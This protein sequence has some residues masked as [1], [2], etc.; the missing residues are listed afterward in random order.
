MIQVSNLSKSYGTGHTSQLL[1]DNVSFNINSGE[2]IGLVGRNGHGKTTLLRLISGEETPDSGAITLPKNYIIG[3]LQQNIRFIRDTVLEEACLGLRPEHKNDFWRAEKMLSGL[4]FSQDDMNRNPSVF[5]GGFQVRLNL[6]KVLAGEPDLLLLDEPTNYLDIVSIRWLS[7]LLNSWKNELLLVTH[8]RSF[9]DSVT[10]HTMGIHRRKIKKIEGGTEKLYNQIIQEE[11]VH[12]KTRQN[13]EKRRKEIEL[14]ITRF[15]A[16]ARLG[17]LVQSRVKLLDKTRKLEKL[18]KIKTLEFS[19]REE[20]YTGK[21]TVE[22]N[23]VSFSYND[24][25]PF[26]IDKFSIV[27][28]K[29]DRIGVIGRNGKGKTTLLKLLAG[30]LQPIDGEVK[31]HPQVKI[32]YFGQTNI[33]QLNDNNTV[34]EEIYYSHPQKNRQE[35]RDICGALL[36]EGDQA[37]KKVSVLSGGEK[38]RVLIGKLLV[39]PTHLLLLDE[40]T[41]HLDMESCDSLLAALD[42][43]DGAVVIVTHNEMFLNALASRL[44]IFDKEKISVF[45]GSYSDFLN[46]VGWESEEGELKNEKI[47]NENS[48]K[49][50]RIAR[51]QAN[52]EKARVLKPLEKKISH[53]ENMI[54]KLE[55]ELH[56]DNQLLIE[57]S[58]KSDGETI[59]I[60]SKKTHQAQSEI[61]NLYGELLKLHEDYEKAAQNF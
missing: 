14:F 24:K 21:W 49:A 32:G 56:T 38:S 16:K 36:F 48:K 40:P 22:G 37:L 12:E 6:A 9:M 41:N 31:F 57:A 25:T 47:I 5:S 29:N 44:I 30:K 55:G 2:R 45:E 58:V 34:E 43:Y 33:E 26:L 11:E 46:D 60:L 20:P 35:A 52:E 19:F 54:S 7:R 13:D 4:G 50:L 27:V 23:Q 42:S 3:Y 53:L 17:G 1:L 59:A 39:S 51:A 15:R 18:E 8:D 61:D 10:T 28:G